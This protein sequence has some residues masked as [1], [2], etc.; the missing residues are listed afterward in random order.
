MTGIR[1]GLLFGALALAPA[2]VG[3]SAYLAPQEAKVP[4]TVELSLPGPSFS[5]RAGEILRS[6]GFDCPE[7]RAIYLV[8]SEARADEMRA[9]CRGLSAPD[10]AA[11]RLIV[12]QSGPFRAEPRNLLGKDAAPG[13]FSLRSSLD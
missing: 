3:V 6:S 2:A 7:L 10:F 4:G 13:E 5:R 8:R 12:R 1:I 9:V 11:I